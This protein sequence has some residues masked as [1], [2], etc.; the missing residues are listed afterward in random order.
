MFT[1]HRGELFLILGALFFSFNGVVVTLVLNHM[2]TFRLAQVRAIGAFALLFLI[3]FIQDR[4]SLRAE[5]KEIPTLMFYGIFGYAMVQLGYFI[6]I[7]RNVP[8]GLVLILE[9]TAPIWIVLWIKFVRKKSVERNMWA[10]IAA[11]LIGL[12]LLA[13]VWQGLTLDLIGLLGS[14]GSAIA[15]AI[16]FLVGEKQGVKRSAQAMT[17]WGLGFASLFWLLLFPIWN[18]PVEFFTTTVQLEGALDAFA[19][20]GWF[21][22]TWIVI[23]GTMIPYL[24][25]IGG[26]RILGASKSSVIGML[27]PVLAGLFA[28]ILL[29]QGWSVIQLIGAFVVLV[30]IYIADKTKNAVTGK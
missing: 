6:G 20:P 29:G 28:W 4:R 19:L 16:Y 30:G 24:F 12:A 9:F 2:S 25:V 13:K 26:M 8:L 21:L 1:K 3:T 23:C 17:V 11:S 15:L 7:A 5:K 18:F 14:I 27:E 10:G 22:I